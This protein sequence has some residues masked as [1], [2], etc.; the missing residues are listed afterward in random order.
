MAAVQTTKQG[1]KVHVN[2]AMVICLD[3]VLLFSQ[4]S[5][6]EKVH[7]ILVYTGYNIRWKKKSCFMFSDLKQSMTETFYFC[8]SAL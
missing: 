2:V 6:N 1:K 5:G 8:K 4:S 3:T 7:I